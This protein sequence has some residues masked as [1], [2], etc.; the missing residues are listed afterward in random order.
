MNHFLKQGQWEQ[1]FPSAPE[2]AVQP[3]HS[4]RGVLAHSWLYPGLSRLPGVEPGFQLQG[5]DQGRRAVQEGGG[6]ARQGKG[7]SSAWG[8][9]GW[10]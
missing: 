3:A 7:V 9:L 1:I 10:G 8:L 2:F 6:L 5:E 4:C